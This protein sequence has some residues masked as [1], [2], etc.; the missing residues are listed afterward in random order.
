MLDVDLSADY[1]FA[2][3]DTPE[4]TIGDERV[5]RSARLLTFLAECTDV[6][7]QWHPSAL[8]FF[9]HRGDGETIEMSWR[10]A[11]KKSIFAAFARALEN[12]ITGISVVER[13][14]TM[15]FADML[16]HDPALRQAFANLHGAMVQ[17]A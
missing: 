2:G 10:G 4:Q 13:N 11:Q 14:D 15:R 8:L 5:A 6:T 16:G 3:A 7:V 12:A 9:R 17:R 1:V